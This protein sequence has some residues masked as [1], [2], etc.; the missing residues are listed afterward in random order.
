MK[1]NIKRKKKK[2]WR[3][4][5]QEYNLSYPFISYPVING[6]TFRLNFRKFIKNIQQDNIVIVNCKLLKHFKN[7]MNQRIYRLALSYAERFID[8]DLIAIHICTKINGN[9][10]CPTENQFSFIKIQNFSGQF[11]FIYRVLIPALLV[12]KLITCTEHKPFL[13]FGSVG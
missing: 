11:G 7:D 6:F 3:K 1:L 13:Y 10:L 2:I 12:Y 8:Y 5:K 9:L 4:E